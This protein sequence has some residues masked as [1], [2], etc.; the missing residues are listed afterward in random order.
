MSRLSLLDST[1]LRIEEPESPMHVASLQI[2][3]IPKNAPDSK[4][5]SSRQLR[6][7]PH[8]PQKEMSS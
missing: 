4:P 1:F 5:P 6:D 2:Y 7:R 8:N 3:R